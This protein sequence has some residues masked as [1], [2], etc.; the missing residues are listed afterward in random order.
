MPN[1][2]VSSSSSSESSESEG[3]LSKR[4]G[5]KSKKLDATTLSNAKALGLLNAA[6]LLQNYNYTLAHQ[7]QTLLAQKGGGKFGSGGPPGSGKGPGKGMGG[8]FGNQMPPGQQLPPGTGG[9]GTDSGPGGGPSSGDLTGSAHAGNLNNTSD[10]KK[11][12][13][14]PLVVA[15]E[16]FA[17]R[18]KNMLKEFVLRLRKFYRRKQY[19]RDRYI[20]SLNE[21]S[22]SETAPATD[23]S[24]P[25]CQQMDEVFDKMR[26]RFVKEIFSTPDL[27][28]ARDMMEQRNLPDNAPTDFLVLEAIWLLVWA[29]SLPTFPDEEGFLENLNQNMQDGDRPR[30]DSP[31]SSSPE[32]NRSALSLSLCQNQLGR[33]EILPSLLSTAEDPNY[34]L[35]AEKAKKLAAL[36]T[37]AAEEFVKRQQS[38][39]ILR[40]KKSRGGSG[41]LGPGGTSPSNGQN[42][43]SSPTLVTIAGS[44]ATRPQPFGGE[45]SS[46]LPNLTSALVDE[47]SPEGNTKNFRGSRGSLLKVKDS[48]K[49]SAATGP[50]G[51]NIPGLQKK[52]KVNYG[53]LSP[54][55]S[56][57]GG[58]SGS[59]SENVYSDSD[60]DMEDPQ[61]QKLQQMADNS[62]LGN[63]NPLAAG[64]MGGDPLGGA[65]P[66]GIN[67]KLLGKKLKVGGALGSEDH[68]L[69]NYPH[70]GFYFG[71][72]GWAG[73]D[74]NPVNATPLFPASSR[75][76]AL[77]QSSSSDSS[78]PLN[79]GAVKIL[80][81]LIDVAKHHRLKQGDNRRKNLLLTAM[82]LL[83]KRTSESMQQAQA[84]TTTRCFAP[85][86]EIMK[87]YSTLAG[88]TGITALTQPESS[89]STV[90]TSRL[91]AASSDL[92]LPKITTSSEEI[93][94][95]KNAEIIHCHPEA[96]KHWA[97]E[98]KRIL[99]EW[100]SALSF[101]TL[102]A[103]QSTV[104]AASPKL[105]NKKSNNPFQAIGG[106]SNTSHHQA[107]KERL[108]YLSLCE[109]HKITPA[110]ELPESVR[111]RIAGD[112]IPKNFVEINNNTL[113]NNS[114]EGD[115][116]SNSKLQGSGAANASS[117]GDS[118][119]NS[120]ITANGNIG[121][122]NMEIQPVDSNSVPTLGSILPPSK[123]PTHTSDGK[124][125]IYLD[126][127]ASQTYQ[128]G[129]RQA[130]ET[131][132]T[133]IYQKYCPTKIKSLSS[134]LTKHHGAENTL[135][136]AVQ[137]KYN[138]HSED[139][140]TNR[141]DQG[142]F[143]ALITAV[144]HEVF[145][146]H[147]PSKLS[148]IS[149]VVAKY[150]NKEHALLTGVC[151][152]YSVCLSEEL[153][154][155]IGKKLGK[156][157]NP[158]GTVYGGNNNGVT[159]AA[160]ASDADRKSGTAA[161]REARIARIA[162][163][164]SEI[165]EQGGVAGEKNV[166]EILTKYKFKEVSLYR[167]VCKKYKV[168]PI[169]DLLIEEEGANLGAPEESHG[170]SRS[171]SDGDGEGGTSSNN[172]FDKELQR[173]RFSFFFSKN[174]RDL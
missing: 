19:A 6:S 25:L 80:R 8:K 118:K 140:Y 69:I 88:V 106:D 65:G 108:L 162:T 87:L 96:R 33:S 112:A 61:F 128:T 56:V 141:L 107:M 142:L 2:E 97:S 73:G 31:N 132:L 163:H 68:N 130:Y 154:Q 53:L 12:F 64:G 150:E 101:E 23:R 91:G 30:D 139:S 123:P 131:V 94:L 41:V 89:L 52:P 54:M 133:E 42:L 166:D 144:L 47:S 117:E 4:G 3:P 164:M 137:T 81:L 11:I 138:L 161:L 114:A 16:Q 149:T 43:S 71:G 92:N 95:G 57:C 90:T 5:A 110:S 46:P 40:E 168:E 113:T 62:T 18:E 27:L 125:L 51:G 72:A 77:A 158:A 26:E 159:A 50:G 82:E 105:N 174:R 102:L 121:T 9:K 39:K 66:G 155:T 119:T 98:S 63:P 160:G 103:E 148:S 55:G 143:K 85:I 21:N 120:T 169:A 173:L 145:K 165:Y 36:G 129:K 45:V 116:T 79:G 13:F 83:C 14:N 48:S 15:S 127:A 44:Q 109:K 7:A 115:L 34:G 147:N 99:K 171:E 167:A 58:S 84:P 24:D 104:V 32:R 122:T 74:M 10:G 134:L 124:P 76:R 126:R 157:V 17:K 20:E 111:A 135:L 86:P 170:S 136:R 37:K 60:Q 153:D 75:S 22:S 28:S 151:D 78:N 70:S 156:S 1:R 172:A 93:A 152:K 49:P 100:G 35:S 59:E 67:P 146:A 29:T 38:K